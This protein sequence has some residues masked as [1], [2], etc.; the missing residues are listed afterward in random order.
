MEDDID[1][2]DKAKENVV[3]VDEDKNTASVVED[4]LHRRQKKTV[5][6]EASEVQDAHPHQLFRIKTEF[7]EITI[8]LVEAK[9]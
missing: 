9:N 6:N 5:K 3:T 2:E 4:T 8:K 1:V 7:T